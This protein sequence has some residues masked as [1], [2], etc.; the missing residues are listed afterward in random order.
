[1]YR[2]ENSF[3]TWAPERRCAIARKITFGRSPLPPGKDYLCALE[4]IQDVDGDFG[5]GLRFPFVATEGEHAGMEAARVTGVRANGTN[6]LGK[7]IADL[8][9]G[10]QHVPGDDVDIDAFVG[11]EFLVSVGDEGITSIKPAPKK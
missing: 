3:E 6:G 1:M 8:E 5:K 9:G 10:V 2:R 7:L 4:T 11:R